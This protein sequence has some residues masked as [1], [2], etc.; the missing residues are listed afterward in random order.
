MSISFSSSFDRQ[1]DVQLKKIRDVL[2]LRLRSGEF[3]QHPSQLNSS[4]STA[5]EQD[6]CTR[7]TDRLDNVPIE[8][9][10]S[11][12]HPAGH[13]VKSRST[14]DSLKQPT[15]NISFKSTNKRDSS[16]SSSRERE[17]HTLFFSI[18]IEFVNTNVDLSLSEC[19]SK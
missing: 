11:D 8:V 12:E 13:F 15:K 7:I 18:T 6:F 10:F 17:R 19:R 14:N 3:V 4:S 9:F 2:C 1:T 16:S 5:V